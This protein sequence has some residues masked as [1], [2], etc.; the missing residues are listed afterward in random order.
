MGAMSASLR[1]VLPGQLRVLGAAF[2]GGSVFAALNI[3]AG[4]LSGAMVAIALLSAFNLAEKLADPLRVLA[5]V[6]SGAAIGAGMSPQMMQGFGRYPASIALMACAVLVI[7]VAGTALMQRMPGFSSQTAFFASVPGALSYV[8]AVAVTTQAD[9]ARIAVVQVL[10]IFFL[11]AVLPLVVAESG[12]AIA[13]P[14]FMAFDPLWL[15]A[16]IFAG[17]FLLGH[18]LERIGMAGGM[19][20]GA[21]FVSGSLHASGLAPGRLPLIVAII[22]QI[23]VGAWSGTR[24]VGFDWRLLGKIFT[25]SL[26]AFAA[27]MAVSAAFAA[28][29]SWMLGTP[30]AATLLAFAPGGLE[31]MTLLAFALGV[32]PLFVGAHHLARFVLISLSLPVVARFLL[33]DDEPLGDDAG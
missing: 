13:T 33:G 3:P 9:M 2:A 19:L 22:A 25:V 11:M 32:D 4:Y 27:T 28:A 5:M 16:A 6:A 17:S 12:I 18:V 31:A 29:S 26:G 7:T 1:Q 30:F 15:V 10:R 24:F 21:M 23:L 14:S 20:F 8:F